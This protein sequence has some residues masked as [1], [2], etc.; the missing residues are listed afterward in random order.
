MFSDA[1]TRYTAQLKVNKQHLHKQRKT[2]E[3]TVDKTYRFTAKFRFTLC[4]QAE[5][6]DSFA[7]KG[8]FYHIFSLKVEATVYLF[9]IHL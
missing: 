8:I 7:I 5:K 9:K 4:M 1:K 3:H 6:K 2:M